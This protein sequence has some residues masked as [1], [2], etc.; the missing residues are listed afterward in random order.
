VTTDIGAEA[1]AE[2]FVDTVVKHHGVPDTIISDRDPRFTSKFW[3]AV[4]KRMG[5]HL[6]MSTAFHPQSDGQTERMN[7]L[8]EDMLRNYV[9]PC[10]DDW[11]LHIAMAE[12]A[13]NNSVNQSTK[14]TPFYLNFGEN[15]RTPLD[16]LAKTKNVPQAK[17]LC[18]RVQENIAIARKYLQQAQQRMSTC[19]NRKRRDVTYLE[20]AE[21]LLNT[22]NIRL[23][24]VGVPKLLPRWVGPFK[25]KK[26]ISRVAMKLDLPPEWKIHDAFHVSLLKP[27][28]RSN[29]HQPLPHPITFEE[30]TPVFEVE[31]IIKVRLVKRGRKVNKEYLVKW[32]GFTQEHNTWEPEAHLQGCQEAI[33]DFESKMALGNT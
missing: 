23:K 30:G 26:V 18:D 15:P 22:K 20:G 14:M 27:Y 24:V 31:S 9:D 7:R 29:R 32:A 19:A 2:V 3:P 12:F 4:M 17:K 11:D 5:T 6:K 16:L 8:L 13:V 10:Q 28:E 33:A 21:V 1:L 25:V